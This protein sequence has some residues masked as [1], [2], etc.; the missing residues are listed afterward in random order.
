MRTLLLALI[1]GLVFHNVE[2]AFGGIVAL[3]E[4]TGSERANAVLEIHK[5]KDIQDL[6][7]GW[8]RG[9]KNASYELSWHN[10]LDLSGNNI[11]PT[12]ILQREDRFVFRVQRSGH[13]KSTVLLPVAHTAPS[14]NKSGLSSVVKNEHIASDFMSTYYRGDWVASERMTVA[15]FPYLEMTD[16]DFWWIRKRECIPAQLGLTSRVFAE[17]H[18]EKNNKGYCQGRYGPVVA[19]KELDY[20]DKRTKN[21][22]FNEVF[23]VFVY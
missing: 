5:S 10:L 18:R 2:N 1:F 3:S 4:I 14:F 17:R 16:V 21:P 13:W 9:F 12:N 15:G 7:I 11:V 6:V 23:D 20:R 8:D 22:F 19:I